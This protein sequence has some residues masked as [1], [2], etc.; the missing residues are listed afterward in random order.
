MSPVPTT[1]PVA[2]VET[3][4]C[5]P[6]AGAPSSP[7][8]IEEV[9]ELI[10]LL[11]KPVTVPCLIESL[12]RPLYINATSN[13]VSAQPAGGPSDP[14][15]FIL[16]DRLVLSIVTAGSGKTSV[17]FSYLN[18]DVDSIK[19]DLELPSEDSILT[20]T[21]YE[22]ILYG[23]GTACRFCHADERAAAKP[24]AFISQAL[25]PNPSSKVSL[26]EVKGFYQNCDAKLDA[27]RC[28]L[29]T[30]LFGHGLVEEKEF[31]AAMSFF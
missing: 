22:R 28:E 6:P 10:N 21:P 18:S 25:R 30:A 24:G 14:R 31:P 13:I 3:R 7:K 1:I 9:V 11:P 4:R 20:S 17:E 27:Y 26:K 16:M 29:Y 2:A 15:I 19:G 5:V 8:T 23:E 12:D